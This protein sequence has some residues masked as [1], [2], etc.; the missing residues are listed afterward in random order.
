MK[1][2]NS[3]P[4]VSEAKKYKLKTVADLVVVGEEP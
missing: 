1:N 4:V 2:T 3:F